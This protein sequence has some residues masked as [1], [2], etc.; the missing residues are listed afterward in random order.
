[1]K[2]LTQKNFKTSDAVTWFLIVL[3][4]AIIMGIVFLS[5]V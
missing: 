3:Y 5:V 2:T 4:P 1:M